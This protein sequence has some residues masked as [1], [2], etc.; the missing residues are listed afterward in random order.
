MDLFLTIFVCASFIFG[1]FGL[2]IGINLTI[3]V[4][5]L[6]KELYEKV[7]NLETDSK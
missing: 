4:N 2:Y 6:E 1:F 7:H 5:K 3:R